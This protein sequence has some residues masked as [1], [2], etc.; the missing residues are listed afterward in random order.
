MVDAFDRLLNI[1]IVRGSGSFPAI[2]Q[3]SQ[4]EWVK[5]IIML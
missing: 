4:N 1:C 3:A 2:E 5:S